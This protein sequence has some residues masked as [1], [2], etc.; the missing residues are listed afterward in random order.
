MHT[1]LIKKVRDLRDQEK[2]DK[3]KEPV[4]ALLNQVKAYLKNKCNRKYRK[5]L[6]I[7]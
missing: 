4:I 1:T 5:N 7:L 2:N 3:F 6:T